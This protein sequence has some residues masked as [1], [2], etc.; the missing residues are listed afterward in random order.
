[1]DA[2]R[3]AV[4]RADNVIVATCPVC[5]SQDDGK[6][7]MKLTPCCGHPLCESCF[8]SIKKTQGRQ[9]PNCPNCRLPIQIDLTPITDNHPIYRR[10][11]SKRM[12]C[13]ETMVDPADFL[14][15]AIG[16]PAIDP[17][18]KPARKLSIYAKLLESVK[19]KPCAGGGGAEMP[20][21][22]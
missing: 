21:P 16:G 4:E 13:V 7:G 12:I 18:P 3:L 8:E 6:C 19:V 17:I 14:E 15:A 9:N 10:V 22:C 20:K 1:M 2:L 5:V 11:E